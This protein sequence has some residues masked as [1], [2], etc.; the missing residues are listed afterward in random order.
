LSIG[1]EIEQIGM[2]TTRRTIRTFP[3][4]KL[5]KLDKHSASRFLSLLRTL[6]TN[7][8]CMV[9][10]SGASAS[11]GIPIW[12]DFLTR[13][14]CAFFYHWDW[15]IQQGATDAKRPPHNL[16]I[17]FTED[18]F[19]PDDIKTF[20]K[21][22]AKNDPLLVAQQIKNCIRPMDWRYLLHKA[23][24]PDADGYT[25][26]IQSSQL[27]KSLADLCQLNH[28]AKLI[29]NYNYDNSMEIHLAQANI[30]YCSVYRENTV[31]DGCVPIYYPHG[32]LPLGG[33]PNCDVIL[34][35]G[36]YFQESINPYSW[37][38]MVQTKAFSNYSC[39]FIGVS[40][41][42]PNLRR[43][44]RISSQTSPMRHFCFLPIESKRT[45]REIMKDALYD[46]DLSL[47][48]VKV[49]R[50]PKLSRGRNRFA[51]LPYLV[52]F[53]VESMKSPDQI[54]R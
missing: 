12:K 28:G 22:F 54:W 18:Y 46:K 4:K 5:S 31:V 36:D 25:N 49:I 41:T 20:S 37:A 38:N 34:S 27:L 7:T 43:L 45:E 32:Y 9:L 3:P 51:F 52:K 11:V 17:A 30:R 42:D 48:N 16:S 33:G 13:L 26:W 21:D 8:I 19:W 15:K 50:F 29:L 10:G 23:L 39:V 14:C 47:L 35:E 44:L 24:Y 2:K 53:L 40:M 1:R 6:Q